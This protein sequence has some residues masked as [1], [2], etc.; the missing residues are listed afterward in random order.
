MWLASKATL[1]VGSSIAHLA[2]ATK[3][4]FR[5]LYEKDWVLSVIGQ[6]PSLQVVLHG[7][8]DVAELLWQ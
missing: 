6:L 4:Y 5:P 8:H 2:M 1:Y 7:R 3:L